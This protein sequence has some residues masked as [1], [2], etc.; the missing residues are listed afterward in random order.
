MRQK[1][2]LTFMTSAQKSLLLNKSSRR[3]D[4]KTYLLMDERQDSQRTGSM[5]KVIAIVLGKSSLSYLTWKMFE[6]RTIRSN[7]ELPLTQKCLARL[8]LQYLKT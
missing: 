1:L 3:G 2:L 7:K 6:C 5:G 4:I 8:V